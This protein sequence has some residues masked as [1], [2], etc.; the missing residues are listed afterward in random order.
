M[1]PTQQF[2]ITL[3]NEMADSVRAKVASGE[4]ATEGEVIRDGLRALIARDKA[5]EA[6][7]RQDVAAAYDALK[8]LPSRAGPASRVRERLA[9]VHVTNYRRRAVIAFEVDESMGRV[10][11][12]GVFDDGQDCEG[13]LGRSVA[14]RGSDFR[15]TLGGAMTR[16]DAQQP[17]SSRGSVHRCALVSLR[18]T[19][20]LMHGPHSIPKPICELD[21]TASQPRTWQRIRASSTR[22]GAS[23]PRRTPRQH[24]SPWHG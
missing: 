20:W 16:C 17:D 13:V 1:R 19:P 8:A 2:S 15:S 21:S 23:V 4:Y 24:R 3:P 9:Q 6:R 7:L 10:F 18:T 22:C 11:I 5:V 14:L 12:L